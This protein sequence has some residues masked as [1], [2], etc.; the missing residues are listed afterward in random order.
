MWDLRLAFGDRVQVEIVDSAMDVFGDYLTRRG[1][2]DADFQFLRAAE[3]EA[4]RRFNPYEDQAPTVKRPLDA[5]LLFLP[6]LL[7]D[8]HWSM[9]VYSVIL[10]QVHVFDSLFLPNEEMKNR[11]RRILRGLNLHYEV[12]GLMGAA[13]EV[14]PCQWQGQNHN[15]GAHAS[16]V[17][18]K[19]IS[20]QNLDR[21]ADMAAYR[22][23]MLQV[24]LQHVA[25]PAE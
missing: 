22:Q 21:H 4:L 12:Q 17:A 16:Y 7:R 18:E 10:K 14:W 19:I 3:V 11:L 13:I 1:D 15:C 9:V 25:A 5:T 20:R 23:N 8:H 2:R 6:S 24:I